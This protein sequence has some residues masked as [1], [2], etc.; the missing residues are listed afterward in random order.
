MSCIPAHLLC[1]Y[2][3]PLVHSSASS[4]EL[5]LPS[6]S[7]LQILVSQST[8]CSPAALIISPVTPLGP[9]AFLTF[10][11]CIACLSSSLLI[12]SAGPS[13]Y[14]ADSSSFHS[15][16][17]FSSFSKYS[18]H[19]SETCS[20]DTR[21]SPLSPFKQLVP[22]ISW[23]LLFFLSFFFC[24]AILKMFFYLPWSLMSQPVFH[25]FSLYSCNTSLGLISR[26]LVLCLFHIFLTFFSFLP[27]LELLPFGFYCLLYLITPPP[28][29]PLSVFAFCYTTDCSCNFS[30]CFFNL[31]PLF[32]N[33][34]TVLNIYIPFL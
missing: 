27:F 10:R 3:W 23:W 6:L 17:S 30:H 2:I 20:S 1:P 28:G 11:S 15:F 24:L 12:M 9:A 21:S 16:S 7:L 8:A 4:L 32:L 33:S 14:S 34:H 22:V 29:L 19:L 18:L 31:V 5:P 25:Y 26:C 13:T